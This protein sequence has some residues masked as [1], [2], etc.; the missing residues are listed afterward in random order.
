MM[1]RS[2]SPIPLQ[3]RT[4]NGPKLLTNN[5]RRDEFKGTQSQHLTNYT[6][7]GVGL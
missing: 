5:E 6:Q 1:I 4:F 2:A 3:A 7:I